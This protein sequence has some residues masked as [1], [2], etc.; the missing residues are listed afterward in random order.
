MKKADGAMTVALGGAAVALLIDVLVGDGA[1]WAWWAVFVGLVA[2][3]YE[4]RALR[5][6][7]PTVR[8]V[9]RPVQND[10]SFG[11]LVCPY[12]ECGSLGQL[13]PTMNPVSGA[14]VSG[15]LT[16]VEGHKWFVVEYSQ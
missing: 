5:P 4:L 2:I 1:R 10:E 13:I 9:K 8:S 7:A 11:W 12:E 14:A 16:C 3:A 6:V 15:T